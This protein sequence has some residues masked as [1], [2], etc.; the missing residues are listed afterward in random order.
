MAVATYDPA[1][2]QTV[3]TST[4]LPSG[5]VV[6]YSQTASV[7]DDEP[8]ARRV[9]TIPDF[10]GGNLTAVD[11]LTPG[12]TMTYF[13]YVNDVRRDVTQDIDI[14][15][16]QTGCW[17]LSL[18]GAQ[19][20]Q[21]KIARE[22]RDSWRSRR[23]R[24]WVGNVIGTTRTVGVTDVR[25]GGRELSLDIIC[26]TDQEL[27]AVDQILRQGVV[28]IRTPIP[29]TLP[30]GFMLIDRYRDVPSPRGGGRIQVDMLHTWPPGFRDS[31][32]DV[33]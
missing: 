23:R 19:S 11:Y 4:G 29:G 28:C 6:V 30:G 7:D 31:L 15:S 10:P 27:A 2:N 25:M 18:D 22:R 13:V 21:I 26:D 32:P 1:T 8:R 5:E 9:T 3:I 20:R 16:Q 12:K 33:I 24:G 14:G 17:L